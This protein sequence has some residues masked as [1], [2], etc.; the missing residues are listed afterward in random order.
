MA[1]I[2]G[3]QLLHAGRE[4]AKERL[5]SRKVGALALGVVSTF[6]GRKRFS[7]SLSLSI[8]DLIGCLLVSE[9]VMSIG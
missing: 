7:L 6:H 2:C 9:R 1:M 5:E 3:Q 4:F 8:L